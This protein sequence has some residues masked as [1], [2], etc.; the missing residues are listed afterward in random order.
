MSIVSRPLSIDERKNGEF[1]D[2]DHNVQRLPAFSDARISRS[3]LT[4]ANFMYHSADKGKY[5]KEKLTSQ[6]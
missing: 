4:N 6:L 5:S 1:E 2:I 3:K